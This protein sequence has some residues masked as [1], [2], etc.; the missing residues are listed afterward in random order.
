[1]FELAIYIWLGICSSFFSFF[2]KRVYAHLNLLY[3]NMME[4][5]TY[6]N[7]ENKAITIG[8]EGSIPPIKI[9]KNK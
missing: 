8:N 6:M 5:D 1:M 9:D 2:L 7:L 3:I 4:L